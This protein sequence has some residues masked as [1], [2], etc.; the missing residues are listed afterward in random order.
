MFFKQGALAV[1]DHFKF[2]QWGDL[3]YF[4]FLAFTD[5]M[6]VLVGGGCGIRIFLDVLASQELALL[7]S[8]PVSQLLK[9]PL[10]I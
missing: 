8:Q 9:T 1:G 10:P 7:L 3:E 5:S 2:I 4:F 6:Q